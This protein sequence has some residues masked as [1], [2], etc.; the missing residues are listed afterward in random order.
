MSDT[1]AQDFTPP[2][3]VATEQAAEMPLGG[4]AALAGAEMPLDPPGPTGGAKTALLALPAWT[5]YLL[6]GSLGLAGLGGAGFLGLWAVFSVLGSDLPKIERLED[7]RPPVVTSVY[8]ADGN[9]IWEFFKEKRAY[10][11]LRDIPPRLRD[12]FLA[13]EDSSFYEHGGVDLWG[14][15][16][17][18]AANLRAGE[19]KQGASTITQQVA[20]SFFLSSE[21]KVTRKIKEIVLARRIEKHLSKDEILTLYLN[22]IY[23]GSGTYGVAAAA[24]VYFHKT[25]PAL[26]LAEAATIAGITPRPSAYAPN[27]NP[28]LALG[29]RRYVL[30]QMLSENFITR[31]EYDQAMAEEARA[32]PR[33]LPPEQWPA[34]AYPMEYLRQELAQI[35]GEDLLF[36]GGLHVLTSIVQGEQEA[37]VT[38]LQAGVRRVDHNGG[39]RGPLLHLSD[40]QARSEWLASALAAAQVRVAARAWDQPA[41]LAPFE[42]DQSYPALVTSFSGP[43]PQGPKSEPRAEVTLAPGQ[44]G[45]IALSRMDWAR[46]PNP[47]VPPEKATIKDPRAALNVGDVVL[48]RVLSA[49]AGKDTGR[50][51]KTAAPGA[52]EPASDSSEEVP[53]PLPLTTYEL[54]LDQQPEVQ[55]AL[56]ALDPHRGRIR[57]M[58]GGYDFAT[59]PFNRAVQAQRQPGSAFKPVIFSLALTRGYTGSTQILDAPVSLPN[60]SEEDLWKPKNYANQFLGQMTLREALTR[61]INTIPVKILMEMGISPT[62]EYAQSLGIASPLAPDNTLA[63]GSSSVTLLE[64]CRAFSVFANGGYRIGSSMIAQIRDGTGFVLLEPRSPWF[65]SRLPELPPPAPA[66]ARRLSDIPLGADAAALASLWS[67]GGMDAALPAAASDEREAAAGRAERIQSVSPEERAN[68]RVLPAATAFVMTNL[69]RGVIEHGTGHEAVALHRPAAG[70]TGTSNDNIDNWFIGYTPHLLAGVWFGY[71]DRRTLG[72]FSAGGNT[73]APAWLDFMQSALEKTAVEDFPIPEGVVFVNVDAKTGLLAR[74]DSAWTI[75]QAFVDGTQ[76]VEYSP[77]EGQVRVEDFFHVDEGLSEEGGA[78]PVPAPGEPAL[79][80]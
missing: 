20:R 60:T 71:D 35:V 80:P 5:R 44:R 12:A 68:G 69:L 30:E 21:R 76:P 45:T 4:E 10:V 17:A 67:P 47:D 57:A 9:K 50:E 29:R 26:T 37:A 59:S 16:R 52:A 23:L 1:K 56:L 66:T 63:L 64:L 72:R 79:P 77:Q 24:E 31:P 42:V 49:T 33:K 15:L 73:A 54:A 70:K 61:S 46:K 62:I 74:P 8:D 55:G 14:V 53:P 48:V 13:A 18:A 41:D 34:M 65:P 2:E 75:P 11:P 6:A 3:G 19:I 78:N 27:V 32:Y 38:A 43:G 51:T 36:Y 7:Y 40:E 22:Q 25:L 39:Y 58:A 28:E